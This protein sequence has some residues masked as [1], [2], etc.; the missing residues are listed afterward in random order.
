MVGT[1][2][3]CSFEFSFPSSCRKAVREVCIRTSI[4]MRLRYSFAPRIWMD[5]S[6]SAVYDL[7]GK[8]I[9]KQI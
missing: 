3:L 4:S 5:S 9:G 2:H 6:D 8:A 7:N 1:T